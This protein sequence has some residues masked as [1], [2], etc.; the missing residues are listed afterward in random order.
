[1]WQRVLIEPDPVTSPTE[2]RSDTK[3]LIRS[4]AK[5]G[6]FTRRFRYRR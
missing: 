1:M 5:A 4:S 6:Y 2:S 3:T